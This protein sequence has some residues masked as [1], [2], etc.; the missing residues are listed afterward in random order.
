MRWGKD[1]EERSAVAQKAQDAYATARQALARA[2]ASEARAAA[3]EDRV[4]A[5]ETAIARLTP[6]QPK[7]K[8]VRVELKRKAA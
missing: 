1:M 5:L 3:L 2:E 7:A 4:E 6:P 8:P